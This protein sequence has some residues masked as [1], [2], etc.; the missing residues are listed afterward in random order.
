MK[1]G[2]LID[3]VIKQYGVSISKHMA[4]RAKRKALEVVDGHHQS[5]YFRI[6][7]YLRT[8]LNTN[9]GSRCIVN[10]IVNPDPRKNPRFHGLFYCLNAQVQGF[11]EGC[12]PFIGKIND[13]MS[14]VSCYLDV[15]LFLVALM[16]ICRCR[17]M[18]LEG[19][20]FEKGNGAP[21]SAS[22]DAHSHVLFKV[23]NPAAEQVRPGKKT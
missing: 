20:F 10:T 2:A 4:Y 19:F 15:N 13:L 12:R 7:D 17:W 16:L 5:Q 22:R 1:S 14:I 3:K 8:V 21:A 9:P 6:R 23:Q 18:F 11:L